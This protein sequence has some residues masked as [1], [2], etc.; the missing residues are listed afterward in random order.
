MKMN[1]CHLAH[2]E[3]LMKMNGCHLAHLELPM[4]MNRCHLAHLELPMKMSSCLQ[5]RLALPMKTNGHR[6]LRLAYLMSVCSC[7]PPHK[8]LAWKCR[9]GSGTGAEKMGVLLLIP[10]QASAGKLTTK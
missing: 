4:K 9:G 1:G 10:L 5:A 3:L 6:Q 8:A 2:L 7:R